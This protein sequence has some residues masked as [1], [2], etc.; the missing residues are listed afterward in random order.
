MSIL[1][2][3]RGVPGSG[4]S[5]YVKNNLSGIYHLEA[6]MYFIRNGKYEFNPNKIKKAHEFTQKIANQIMQTGADLVVSNTFTRIWEF[7]PYLKMAGKYG[8]EVKVIRLNSLY[9]N[10]HGVPDSVVS[11]MLKRF[12]D[13]KGEEN[14]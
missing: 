11:D 7:E 12:E 1:H 14:V 8:Y 9:K 5:T 4:K 6:D 3:I 10:T 13:Y 2:I